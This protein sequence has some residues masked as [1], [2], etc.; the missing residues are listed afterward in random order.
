[1]ANLVQSLLAESAGTAFS[2][3]HGVAQRLLRSGV[4]QAFS[5]AYM[6]TT[7]TTWP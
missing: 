6:I 7:P 4:S 5:R 1:M 3:Q 2:D